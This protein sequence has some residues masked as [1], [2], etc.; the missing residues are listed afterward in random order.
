MSIRAVHRTEAD[1]HKLGIFIHKPGLTCA[2]ENLLKIKILPLVRQ[3]DHL[4]RMIL[5][6]SLHNGCQICRII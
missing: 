6:H 1:M 2:A 4:I 5:T 3:I